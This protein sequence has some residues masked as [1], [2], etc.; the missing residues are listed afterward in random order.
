MIRSI[1]ASP[2]RLRRSDP[3]DPGVCAIYT[4]YQRFLPA[5]AEQTAAE[6][7]SAARSCVDCKK[8]LTAGVIEYFAPLRERR[9]A[10][11]SDPKRLDEIIDDGCARA[12]AVALA[13]MD[14]VREAM[15]IG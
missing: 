13:T 9:A 15:G 12:R 5:E 1:W 3:G 6:C 11:E 4:W 8:R 7:R 10:Y 14:V 2:Q